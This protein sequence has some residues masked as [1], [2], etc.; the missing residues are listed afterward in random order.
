MANGTT[1]SP[2]DHI[3][4]VQE[5]SKAFVNEAYRVDSGDMMNST[6]FWKPKQF[7]FVPS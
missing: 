1:A 6:K 5:P 3:V 7:L 2:N 4:D